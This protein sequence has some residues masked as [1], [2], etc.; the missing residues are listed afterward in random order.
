MELEVWLEQTRV[1]H[2]AHD[3]RAHRFAL[4]YT[5]EWLSHPRRYP[6]SPRL[7]LD[8][9]AGQ[10]DEAHS[11]EVRQFFENLLPEGEALDHAA[12]A[13][14]L[15]KA[16]LMG[17]L[18]ALGRETAGALRIAL[19]GA[20]PPPSEQRRRLL[21][22]GE[23][24]QRIRDRDH[25]PF[26]VW[27]GTVRLSIAGLQDKIAVYEE[28]GRWY[29]VDDPTLAST[30]IVK[31]A[32]ARPQLAD[33]PYNE[34]FCMRL[35]ARCGVEAAEVQLHHVPEP[36][37]FVRRFD[38]QVQADGVRRLHVVD[39]CQA[40]GLPV[41]MK[42]ERNYGDRE[43]VRHIRDGASL[44]RMF[45]LLQHSPRPI[46]DRRKLLRWAIFQ[47][48]IRNTDAHG[49]NVSFYAG[50]E[51]LRTAPAYDLVCMPPLGF[52]HPMA[53]AIGDAFEEREITPFEWASFAAACGVQPRL[54]AQEL[55]QL[56]GRVLDELPLLA[57]ESDALVP[58]H[59]CDAIA[60]A[61]VPVAQRHMAL[62]QEVVRVKRSYL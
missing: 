1:A 5:P 48:L 52:E 41:Q 19:P 31:P 44:P 38:R 28:D 4:R 17:L 62:A 24:S 35:A 3:A 42:Y 15:S 25:Q 46:V 57:R 36:V 8:R 40:L 54:L 59:V 39:G 55:G 53:M 7:P 12:E 30:F 47:V 56:C 13:N 18:I 26:S 43:E 20:P 51:G 37:L 10:T 58:K 34:F 32:P 6:L 61:V 49:K 11:A 33:V 27:D 14:G 50:I 22:P 2:L 9:P 29:L 21:T 45:G 60:G 16:N 23:L